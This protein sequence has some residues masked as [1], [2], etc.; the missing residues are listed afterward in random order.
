[1]P[2]IH[3]TEI[4]LF[5][6][7]RKYAL[8]HPE[9][10]NGNSKVKYAAKCKLHGTNAAVQIHPDG[11]VIAQS[12]TTELSIDNDNFGFARF[13]ADYEDEWRKS[14][15]IDEGQIYFGE[16]AG[17]NIQKGVALADVKEKFFAVFATRSLDLGNDHLESDWV[18][19]KNATPNCN[20][21]VKNIGWLKDNNDPSGFFEVEIDW[22]ASDEELKPALDKINKMVL[23]VE[24]SDPWVKEHFGVDGIGEGIVLYP[25][26]T[27]HK[28]SAK[29]FENLSFKAKG[30][31][32]RTVKTAA[33]AQLNADV[34][35]SVEAFVA[36]VMTVARMEQG[37]FNVGLD[38]KNTGK[39][40]A[41][42][43]SDVEK[44]TQDELEAAKLE[45]KQVQKLLSDKARAWYL[46][47]VKK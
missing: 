45:W 46:A 41:W 38:V 18:Y 14:M 43:L 22:L 5:N 34:A 28:S 42:V 44:E 13:V 36:M 35:A 30:E 21:R 6:N 17:G 27:E 40:V 20:G 8:A 7:V 23:V 47:E 25:V 26:S 16:W 10:L 2:V 3:W 24:K 1:M 32:H 19:L 15:D 37:V 39:F 12:R 33:P 9:I 29:H 4:Q 11:R 31:A